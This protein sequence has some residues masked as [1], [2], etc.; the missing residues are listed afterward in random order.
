MSNETDDNK[1]ED[2]THKKIEQAIESGNSISSKELQVIGF[3]LTL[4]I[5][6]NYLVSYIYR[7]ISNQA[8]EIAL[9]AIHYDLSN[10][11]DRIFLYNTLIRDYLFP[12]IFFLLIILSLVIIVQCS[13]GFPHFNLERL[14]FNFDSFNFSKNISNLFSQSNLFEF[15]KSLFKLIILFII[16][17]NCLYGYR[18][19]LVKSFMLDY[20]SALPLLPNILCNITMTLLIYLIIIAAADYFYAKYKWLINLR[21]TRQE[22]K[23]EYKESEG[24]P[25]IK[26]RQ[27]NLRLQKMRNRMIRDVP[28]STVV[29]TN[30]THFAIA[31]RYRQGIDPAPI[32]VAKGVDSLAEKIKSIAK[33]NN[34]HMIE[35]KPLA[36]SLYQSVDVGDVIPEE[37]YKVLAEIITMLRR[38]NLLD[39]HV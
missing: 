36:R 28:S 7:I 6:I 2:A 18:N 3:L 10:F 27:R 25:L 1:T 31:L 15:G 37:F 38:L 17:I 26:S 39:V 8:H 11:G 35:N 20:K 9:T 12:F 34:V 24:D 23:E 19:D 21:M 33:E 16:T 32:V 14:K 22:L 13:Q 5:I 30:P 29:I 4:Y